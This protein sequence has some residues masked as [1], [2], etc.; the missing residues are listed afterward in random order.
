MLTIYPRVHAAA[1]WPEGSQAVLGEG[2]DG[3]VVVLLCTSEAGGYAAQTDY[4]GTAEFGP[5]V[6][7]WVGADGRAS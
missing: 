7:A 6:L 1:E 2:R 3:P 5:G 4:L